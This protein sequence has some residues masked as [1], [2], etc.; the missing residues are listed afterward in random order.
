MLNPVIGQRVEIVVLINGIYQYHSGEILAMPDP[1]M[2]SVLT[3]S[4]KVFVVKN[5]DL[6][7]VASEMQE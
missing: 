6:I 4:G 7:P 3:D 1:Y 2:V 5:V